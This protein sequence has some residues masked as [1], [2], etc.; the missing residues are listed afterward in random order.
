MF[1][2]CPECKTA[3]YITIAEL[4]ASRGLKVCH[5]CST[6]FNALASLSDVPP[7][8]T[9]L[10]LENIDYLKAHPRLAKLFIVKSPLFWSAGIGI[11]LLSLLLQVFS[12]QYQTIS[13]D[14]ELRPWLIKLC[15]TLHCAI[16]EYKNIQEISVLH[17]ELVVLKNNTYQ[18][19]ST[20]TNQ[21]NFKQALPTIKLSF[22]N[23]TG[24]VVAYRFFY[25]KDFVPDL[26]KLTIESNETLEVGL[27]IAPITSPIGGYYFD[28]V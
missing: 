21:A 10:A 13:Q 26:K 8:T 18:F 28:L 1:S 14:P 17:G 16:P 6:K 22:V 11:C 27:H 2:Q 7:V 20:W 4:R 19:S 23:F 24:E 25:P 15:K 12:Y 5:K 9:T 3:Y